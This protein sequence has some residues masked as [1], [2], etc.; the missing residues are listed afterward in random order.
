MIQ[1][2]INFSGNC[3]EAVE[4]YSEVFRTEKPKFML[5]GDV[6]PDPAFPLT[7]ASKNLIMHT[8]L[9]VTGSKI[10]FSDVPADMPFTM[11]NNMS[12]TVVTKDADE[13]KSA[14]EKLKVGG[15]I[16]MD[17]QQTFWSKLY[18]SLTDKF[19]IIWQFSLDSGEMNS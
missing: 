19:G 6:P 7:E 8:E 15:T 16:M 5:Y 11:G 10:M 14:F 12:L 18:G 17:L 3:R 4:L 2:Y 1:V 13:I 9:N